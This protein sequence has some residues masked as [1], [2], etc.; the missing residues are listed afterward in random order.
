MNAAAAA[1]DD[2][3]DSTFRPSEASDTWLWPIA[4]FLT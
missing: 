2:G 3:G 4:I 1:D